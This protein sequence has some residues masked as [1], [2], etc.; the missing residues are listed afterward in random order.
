[1]LS[2]V[3]G[4][5]FAFAQQGTFVVEDTDSENATMNQYMIQP[6]DTLWD[7]A[8]ANFGDPQYWPQLWSINEYITNP[9]WIYP[10]N[11]IQFTPGTTIEPPQ[12]DIIS[13]K[14]IGY[15]VEQQQFG[16]EESLCGP[17]I[18]FDFKQPTGTFLVPGFI[19]DS[20]NLTVLG[21]VDA[22]PKNQSFLIENNKVYMR[23]NDP[24]IYDCGDV[25]T[26]V[27][28]VKRTVRHPNSYF[29]KYGSMYQVI[30][31]VR[32]LH[33]YGNYVVGEIRNSFQEMNRSDLVI[34]SRP[35]MVQL[36]VEKPSGNLQ[37]VVI[38]RLAQRHSFSTE[39]DTLFIDRGFAD[40][41]M[42]GDTFYIVS[43]RDPYID[44]RKDNYDLP[45]SVIG[46]VVIV[47]V[48]EESSVAVLTDVHTTI[49]LEGEKAAVSVTQSPF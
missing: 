12:I 13:N 27:R 4:M 6:G 41:V 17:D 35:T 34:P 26:V 33:T 7:L 11:A 46:R 45:P 16:T 1:M 36:E 20:D 18:R 15:V 40:G 47:D 3:M 37:G 2:L 43:Q 8:Q 44:D 30:G 48:K 10:G 14:E 22:S 38:D 28:K 21:T 19:E 49:G 5:Q 9:H 24:E 31:D 42:V 29:K 39:R 32:I 25:V 23:L